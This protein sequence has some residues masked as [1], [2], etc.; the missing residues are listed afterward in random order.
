MDLWNNTESWQ[1]HRRWQPSCDYFQRHTHIRRW[2]AS[3]RSGARI[4]MV[5]SVVV[6][7]SHQN[8]A[9]EYTSRPEAQDRGAL[10]K[11]PSASTGERWVV[12]CA[13]SQCHNLA[14]RHQTHCGMTH[15]ESR[16]P[17][18]HDRWTL[19]EAERRLSANTRACA[20]QGENVLDLSGV[21]AGLYYVHLANGTTW[22][23][24]SKLV[25]E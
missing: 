1:L 6:T 20:G 14:Q 23:A 25:V 16:W 12:S 9:H 11:H 3:T 10:G 8:N 4:S 18:A 15:T 24:G 22:L 2:N 7:G 19:G 13:F 5:H 17:Q 21:A